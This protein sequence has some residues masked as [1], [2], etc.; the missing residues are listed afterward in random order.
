MPLGF[1]A[2]DRK[3]LAWSLSIFT[4]VVILLAILT[5]EEEDQRPYPSTY[6]A[7]AGGGKAAYLMLQELGYQVERW[8]RKP[9]ELPAPEAGKR[10]VLILAEPM[11]Y[12]VEQA[13]A[14]A[15]RKFIATGGTVLAT[16][17]A[18]NLLPE[19]K[20]RNTNEVYVEPVAFSPAAPSRLTRGGD[21][22]MQPSAV[23]AQ[24]DTRVVPH[25]AKGK[26]VV[27]VSYRSG[28]GEVIWWAS[29]MPITNLRVR[30]AGNINLLLNA[31]GPP[32]ATRV[33]W[34][35][36][37]HGEGPVLSLDLSNTPLRWGLWQLVGFTLAIVL[38]FSRRS[39][40]VRP[41]RLESRLSP[42]ETVRSLGNLFHRADATQAAVEV[43]YERFR[44][45]ATSRLGL[46]RDVAAADLGRS[47]RERLGLDEQAGAV[48]QRCEEARNDV[49][50]NERTALWL[51]QKLN[52]YA[53]SANLISDGEENAAWKR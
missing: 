26:D 9:A 24:D 31:L 43:S 39:L 21:I 22:L 11:G 30:E 48:L 44:Y 53:R 14:D 37:F 23:W 16:G 18:E 36:Y 7:Q 4:V 8:Q 27:V 35:E 25:Y 15:V 50:L 34:D 13:D 33:L 1:A 47:L 28:S 42:L 29:A 3:L 12:R 46:R 2:Q 38:T 17:Y 32:E 41:L 20:I 51:V 49:G 10:T 19:A 45:L 5:P 52:D 40:P 6:S